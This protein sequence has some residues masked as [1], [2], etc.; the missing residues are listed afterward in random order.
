[1]IVLVGNFFGKTFKC[2]SLLQFPYLCNFIG[3]SNI[4]EM[5]ITTDQWEKTILESTCYEAKLQI[6]MQ[7]STEWKTVAGFDRYVR[8]ESLNDFLLILGH[9]YYF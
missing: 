5:Q 1:M 7:N 9:L 6:D 2:S 3:A 8:E 4:G